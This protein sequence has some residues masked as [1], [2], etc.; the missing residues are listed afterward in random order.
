MPG[1]L[2]QAVAAFRAGR[3]V[4]TAVGTT[5]QAA[6]SIAVLLLTAAHVGSVTLATRMLYADLRLGADA[7][8]DLP[9]FARKL[10]TRRS[11]AALLSSAFL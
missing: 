7:K 9:Q 5:D 10:I 2:A 4:N 11:F 6:R 3:E 1:L 8:N